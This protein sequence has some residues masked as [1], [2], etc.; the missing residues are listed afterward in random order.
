MRFG[1]IG[2]LIV[3]LWLVLGAV[4]AYERGYFDDEGDAGCAKAGTVVVTVVAGPL[5]WL[6]VNPKIKCDIPEPSK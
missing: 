3:L 6:G 4:A 2:G 1:S 5:N